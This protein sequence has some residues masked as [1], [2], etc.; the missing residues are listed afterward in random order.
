MKGAEK[1][2][3]VVFVA[4]PIK[5]NVA[6]N[7]RKV[8][9]ICRRLL[10]QGEVLPIV[11]YLSWDGVLDDNIPEERNLGIEVN[12]VFF[13]RRSFDELWLYGENIS[14]SEGVCAE[15]E[16]AHAFGIPVVPRTAETVREYKTMQLAKQFAPQ[17]VRAPE[18]K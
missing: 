8:R 7:L 12:R 15:I 2:K 1:V 9:E 13:E 14:E 10:K 3:K 4:H 17:E 16:L 11:P 6:G 5:G 18:R